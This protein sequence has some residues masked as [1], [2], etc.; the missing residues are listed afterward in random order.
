[1][2]LPKELY[3]EFEFFNYIGITLK[4]YNKIIYYKS[5]MY[6]EFLI[7][8]GNNKFRIINAPDDRL[9]YIQHKIL[10]FIK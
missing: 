9:K 8:K 7:P 2:I 6:H 3:S 5:K 4:E 10:N 1:M